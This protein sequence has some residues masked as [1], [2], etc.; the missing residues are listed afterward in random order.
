MDLVITIVS[1]LVV[2]GVLIFVHELGHFLVAK[3]AGV[4]VTTFSLGFG[5]KL[6]AMTRGETE[7]RL[8]MVPLGGYVRM[9]G[10]NPGEEIDPEDIPRSFSHKPVGWRFAI[11]GA[12]PVSNLLFALVTYYLLLV[13]WGAPAPLSAQVGKLAPGMPAMEAGMQPGDLVLAV[14]G[15]KIADWEQMRETIVASQGRTLEFTIDRA[16]RELTLSITP[17]AEGLFA[18]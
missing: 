9:V 10:E 17:P 6:W 3:K 4:G 18:S 1:A 11:V 16:G 8:S 12:G 15:K 13:I 2:L 7:Y 14:D 5:P